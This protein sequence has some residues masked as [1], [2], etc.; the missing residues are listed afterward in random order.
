MTLALGLLFAFASGCATE[1]RRPDALSHSG[2]IEDLRAR[3]AMMDLLEAEVD[4][5]SHDLERLMQEALVHKAN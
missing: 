1:S 5:M 2:A 4:L 3:A